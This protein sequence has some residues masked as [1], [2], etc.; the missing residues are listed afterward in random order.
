MIA[1]V[2]CLFLAVWDVYEQ[3]LIAA[4]DCGRISLAQVFIITTLSIFIL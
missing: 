4:L 2:F 1:D 3:V